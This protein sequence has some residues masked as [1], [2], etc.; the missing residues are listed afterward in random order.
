[1]FLKFQIEVYITHTIAYFVFSKIIP[2]LP[3][4]LPITIFICAT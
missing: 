2:I 3:L 1:M 4:S